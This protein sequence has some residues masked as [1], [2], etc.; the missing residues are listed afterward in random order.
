MQRILHIW[1]IPVFPLN[2]Q[3]VAVVRGLKRQ[4]AAASASFVGCFLLALSDFSLLLSA[5]NDLTGP[6]AGPLARTTYSIP[7]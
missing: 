4:E 2:I 7:Y 6:N 5:L 1:D 3:P